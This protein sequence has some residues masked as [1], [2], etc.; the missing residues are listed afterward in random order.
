[1]K[2]KRAL[3]YKIDYL[4]QIPS[5]RIFSNN[6]Y[7]TIWSI[8][9]S[10]I[11]IIIPIGFFVYSLAEYLEFGNPNVISIKESSTSVKRSINLNETLL[12]FKVS[13]F[14]ESYKSYIEYDSTEINYMLGGRLT[15]YFYD[16]S[17]E[18]KEEFFQL[19]K[20]ELG[21][22]I[23]F[24]LKD[25]IEEFEK[26]T[27]E[28]Y[29]D[30]YC[31]NANNN[32]EL[33]YHP[34]YGYNE[35]KLYVFVDKAAFN[36]HYSVKS[37][38]IVEDDTIN[39]YNRSFPIIGG[40]KE[41]SSSKF[42]N[43]TYSLVNIDLDYF[44]YESD[45][46]IFLE[47]NTKNYSGVSFGDAY[48]QLLVEGD[49]YNLIPNDFFEDNENLLLM[50][51]EYI[52]ISQKKYF[53]SY[54]RNYQKIQSFIAEVKSII[55][56]AITVCTYLSN[57][58]SKK[59]MKID[60]VVSL[61]KKKSDIKSRYFANFKSIGE[62]NDICN[63]INFCN[64]SFSES[65]NNSNRKMLI[66]KNSDNNLKLLHLKKQEK[67]TTEAIFEKVCLRNKIFNSLNEKIFEK[68]N[69]C[70]ILRSYLCCCKTWR[71]NLVNACVDIANKELCIDRILNRLLILEKIYYLS[72]DDLKA[73]I[74]LM[75][76]PELKEVDEILMKYKN[77]ILNLKKNDNKN[78][79]Y[80]N[81]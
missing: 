58:V 42:E 34:N 47:T 54:K 63:E 21:K 31:I 57:I 18:K 49:K 29:L 11:S 28:S 5:L 45:N 36:T 43:K 33:Y 75:G 6:N 24:N 46:S 77:N 61:L 10:I 56:I 27:S 30:Y 64:D 32:I 44:K 4:S 2:D 70:D 39:N 51:E 48:T 59:K 52:K 23:N 53:D 14:Y 12:M 13:D 3:Y 79:I 25:K 71:I 67:E 16:S 19:E 35:I 73:K 20:C 78:A 17:K 74:Q 38:I 40:F 68:I 72:N 8:I 1:M 81:K 7:K 22:T 15:E 41:Y 37:K 65:K 80:E 66:E 55:E 60:I 69:Y 62:Y 50:A 26:Y 9:V 76:S